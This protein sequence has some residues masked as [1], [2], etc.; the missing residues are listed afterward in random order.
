MALGPG[1]DIITSKSGR[2]LIFIAMVKSEDNPI[3]KR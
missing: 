3:T 2:E 1:E